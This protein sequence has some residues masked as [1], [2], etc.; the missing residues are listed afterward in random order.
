MDWN[1]DGKNDM[2]DHAFYNNVIAPN[3]NKETPCYSKYQN[4][5]MNSSSQE[6]SSGKGSFIFVCLVVLY[7]IVKVIGG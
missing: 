4:K 5:S 2:Q 3:D 6:T 1:N 7:I